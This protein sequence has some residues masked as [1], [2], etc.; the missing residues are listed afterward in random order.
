M[1]KAEPVVLPRAPKS[2]S[3]SGRVKRRKKAS[4][5]K[6]N[7]GLNLLKVA[8]MLA[9][10]R[11]EVGEHVGGT[12]ELKAELGQLTGTTNQALAQIRELKKLV[13]TLGENGRE[14]EPDTGLPAARASDLPVAPSLP[15]REGAGARPVSNGG[16]K[17]LIVDDDPT[18]LKIIT[19]FLH[20]ENFSVSSSTSGVNGLKKAFKEDPDLILLDIMMPD[21]NGFQFLSI[22]QKEEENARI[23]VVILSSLAEE[24]DILKALEIGAVDF[25]TKPFSPQ[26]LMA[27]IRKNLNDSP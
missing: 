27:K 14:H 10:V 17:I 22:Y 12:A 19:H 5:P 9:Q 3:K 7:A 13:E 11:K 1:E 2:G 8:R 21:L 26:V 23:P 6:V 18:T 15:D 16:K 25:I 20:K 24:A 4:R